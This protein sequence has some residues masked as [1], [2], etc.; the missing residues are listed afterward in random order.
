[1]SLISAHHPL[2]I[3]DA[4]RDAWVDQ[5]F[6]TCAELEWPSSLM[7][8]FEPFIRNEARIAQWDGQG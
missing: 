2:Q 3:S 5:M 8:V 6:A 1:M 7:A 4:Q